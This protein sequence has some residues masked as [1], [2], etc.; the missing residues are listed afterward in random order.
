[1]NNHNLPI[2][3]DVAV[4]VFNSKM[5]Y[6]EIMH[7]CIEAKTIKLPYHLNVNYFSTT[8]GQLMADAIMTGI[9]LSPIFFC[10]KCSIRQT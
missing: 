7:L 6:E 4:D 10:A 9:Q 8:N 5:S 2:F 3:N 1:M